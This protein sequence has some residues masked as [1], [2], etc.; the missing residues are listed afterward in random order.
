M[1]ATTD[2]PQRILDVAERLVQTRGFNG[3]SYADI[4]DALKV[5]KASLHYERN[6]LVAL[7][8]IDAQ[9]KDAR[10]RLRRYAAIYGSVLQHDRMCL[11]GM[12]AAEYGTLPEDMRARMRHYFEENE[13]WLVAVLRQGRKEKSLKFA[14]TPAEAAR[15]LVGSLEGAMML[16]RSFADPA[17]FKSA[18]ERLMV[19][20]G[21]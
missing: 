14:G 5:T 18:S 6:F 19:E 16:A 17:R 4:A 20:L 12:L 8:A 7:Q 9:G 15:A 2:T 11:C 1:A 3:F 13:R 10:D 21:A